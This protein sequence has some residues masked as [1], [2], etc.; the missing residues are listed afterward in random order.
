MTASSRHRHLIGT[1]SPSSR[2]GLPHSLSR[3]RRAAVARRGRGGPWPGRGWAGPGAEKP[4]PPRP[5]VA[6]PPASP[7]TGLTNRQPL[8]SYSRCPMANRQGSLCQE[9]QA[10][11]IGAAPRPSGAGRGRSRGEGVSGGPAGPAAPSAPQPC[12]GEPRG[13]WKRPRLP[14]LEAPRAGALANGFLAGQLRSE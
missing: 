6:G 10:Q 7:K 13:A 2:R 14:P 5:L 11:P 4:R 8:T 12:A 9:R 1:A 3:G